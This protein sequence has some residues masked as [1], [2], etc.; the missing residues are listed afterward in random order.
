[1]QGWVDPGDIRRKRVLLLVGI[2]ALFV[3]FVVAT[4]QSLRT[5]EAEVNIDRIRYAPVMEG[6]DGYDVAYTYVVN[7]HPYINRD[8]M[9][10]EPTPE[11]QPKVCYRPGDPA[12]H[13]LVPGG[14]K[15][16]WSIT[17]VFGS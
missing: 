15:C 3:V 5:A 6:V 11:A 1:V 10:W 17:A 9:D 14:V 2:V 16:E 13:R 4:G 7:L 12:N 8:W